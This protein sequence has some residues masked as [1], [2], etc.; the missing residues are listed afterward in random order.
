[1]MDLL[2][3]QPAVLL[4]AT[5]LLGLVIGSFLNVLIHRLPLMMERQWQREARAWLGEEAP[6]GEGTDR[7]FNLLV[8]RS[9]CPACGHRIRV[10]ENIPVLSYLILRG[11]CAACRTRI[12]PQY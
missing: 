11:R 3:A 6:T 10:R 5:A 2:A 8:P 4:S 7:P 12:S 9:R 1:M